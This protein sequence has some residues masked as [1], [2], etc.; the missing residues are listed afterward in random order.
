MTREESLAMRAGA[1]HLLP[2]FIQLLASLTGIAP[3]TN[4]RLRYARKKAPSAT[5][6]RTQMKTKAKTKKQKKKSSAASC[7]K[8]LNGMNLPLISIKNIT[9]PTLT[10]SG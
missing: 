10:L 2:F 9:T 1:H 6:E 7:G 5:E 4:K 8:C 3:R